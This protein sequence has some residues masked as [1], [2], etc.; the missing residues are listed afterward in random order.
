MVVAKQ[1]F[2]EDNAHSPGYEE[3]EDEHS[4]LDRT[5]HLMSDIY[6]LKRTS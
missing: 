3:A 4:E 6:W 2:R 1:L 5:L